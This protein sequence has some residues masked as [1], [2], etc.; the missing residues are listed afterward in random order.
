MKLKQI[1]FLGIFIINFTKT[2]LSDKDQAQLLSG[3]DFIE[4]KKKV[5]TKDNSNIGLGTVFLAGLLAKII[6][7]VSWHDQLNKSI[8]ELYDK[9]INYIE[10]NDI[11]SL[12]DVQ[13]Y[14]FFAQENL[15]IIA[16]YENWMRNSYDSYFKFWNWN[17]EQKIAYEKIKLLSMI[18]LHGPMIVLGDSLKSQDIITQARKYCFIISKYPL[19]T[20]SEIIDIHIATLSTSLSFCVQG[21][22]NSFISELKKNIY[23]F[24]VLFY[25]DKEYACEFYNFKLH[26]LPMYK[27]NF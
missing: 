20:Y 14:N 27:S 25:S 1:M 12:H 15:E 16:F 7:D 18:A 13:L 3:Q 22:I 4:C 10:I 23:N 11:Q 24:R 19:I 2:S 26:H 21:K 5:D 6:Y 8:S 17:T 9:F